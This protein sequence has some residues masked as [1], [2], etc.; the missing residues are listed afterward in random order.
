MLCE[1]FYTLQYSQST[2]N[3]QLQWFSEIYKNPDCSSSSSFSSSS[4]QTVYR[5][6]GVSNRANSFTKIIYTGV[7]MILDT[8]NLHTYSQS[9]QTLGLQPTSASFR[10][11]FLVFSHAEHVKLVLCSLPPWSRCCCFECS[12]VFCC[13]SV[14]LRCSFVFVSL[15]D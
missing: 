11:Y 10:T 6:T 7:Y 14:W 2:Q 9:R 5:E 1:C 4:V 8:Q 15:N 12:V 13:L 3:I